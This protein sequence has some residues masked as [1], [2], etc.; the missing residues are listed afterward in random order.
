MFRVKK[1]TDVQ[2]RV[3]P[4]ACGLLERVYKLL[5]LYLVLYVMPRGD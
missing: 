3:L 5:V 2:D 4:R 1:I